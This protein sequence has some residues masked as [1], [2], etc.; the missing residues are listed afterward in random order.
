LYFSGLAPGFV[1]LY[2]VNIRVP[3]DL[4]SGDLTL[5]ILSEYA[6]SQTVLLTVR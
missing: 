4:A 1:G 6:D 3:D 2:Q 5:R